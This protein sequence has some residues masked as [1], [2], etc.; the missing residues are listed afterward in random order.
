MTSASPIS[1]VMAASFS[2]SSPLA[3]RPHA[4][5]QSAI[6]DMTDSMP[7]SEAPHRINGATEI[8]KSMPAA[9]PQAATGPPWRVVASILVSVIEPTESTASA[10]RGFARVFAASANLLRSPISLAHELA[11]TI[12]LLQPPVGRR[13][14][15]ATVAK[16]CNG[17][18]ADAPAAPITTGPLLG[19]GRG[20]EPLRGCSGRCQ[21]RHRLFDDRQVDRCR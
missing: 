6:G 2:R 12:D 11:G 9:H 14:L 16:N 18:R 13:D 21:S 7:N 3:R 8:G 19:V 20:L 1:L 17:D 15:K 4:V 10:Q 5:R